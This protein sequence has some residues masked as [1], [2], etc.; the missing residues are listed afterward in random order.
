MEKCIDI[1]RHQGSFD[2]KTAKSSGI[3]TVIA[4]LAYGTATD[5]KL[6]QFAPAA[7]NTGLKLGGYGFLTAHYDVVHG[8]NFEKAKAE[9]QKQVAHWVALAKQY[10]INSWLGVDIELESG[11]TCSLSK[12]QLTSLANEAM[13]LLTMGGFS[14]CIYASVSWLVGRM[15]PAEINYPLWVAHYLWSPNDPDFYTNGNDGT[16]PSVGTYASFYKAY[17]NK[18]CAWQFGRI[19]YGAKYGAG[20][21][22]LDKN[23]LYFSPDVQAGQGEHHMQEKAA[24]VQQVKL[25]QVYGTGCQY[26]EEANPSRTVDSGWNKGYLE[27]GKSYIITQAGLNGIHGYNWVQVVIPTG[28]L[29]YTA[30]IED[31]CTVVSHAPQNAIKYILETYCEEARKEATGQIVQTDEEN[32]KQQGGEA[33]NAI[34]KTGAP[35]SSE[36]AEQPQ[37]E[38]PA[39]TDEANITQQEK[40]DAK[41]YQSTQAMLAWLKEMLN[42]KEGN[43][44]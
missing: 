43:N 7:K 30:L 40:A 21:A 33:G 10:Q 12:P 15:N 16:L 29:F 31:R 1:S 44:T 28:Q 24:E 37:S 3:E 25:L 17:K 35:P 34:N 14:A 20:S 4:R 23:W 27:N 41:P 8:G 13:L 2:A 5:T 38:R 39:A 9:M 26:F 6:A 11:F 22:N 19:G 36:K 18:I 42:L 32:T